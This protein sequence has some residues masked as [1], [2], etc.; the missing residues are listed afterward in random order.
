MSFGT[1]GFKSPFAHNER[2]FGGRN[3][4]AT[5]SKEVVALCF[6]GDVVVALRMGRSPWPRDDSVGDR[7][8]ALSDGQRT[9]ILEP[10]SSSQTE[11]AF[12]PVLDDGA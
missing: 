3:N 12:I 9:C 2:L 1:W 8:A 7:P 5:I 6:G 4:K 10:Q 11:A